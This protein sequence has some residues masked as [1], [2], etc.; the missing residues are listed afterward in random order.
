MTRNFSL[1]RGLAVA[2]A[3]VVLALPACSPVQRVG[4]WVGLGSRANLLTPDH[5]EFQRTAP[6][7]Y[8]VRFETSQGDFVVQVVRDWAPRGADRFYNLV[9][10]G[11]YDDVRFFRVLDGFMAQFGMSGDPAVT[12]A[13]QDARIPDDPVTRANTRGL[14]SFATAGPNTRTTQLFINFGDNSRLDGLGFAP[15]GHVIEGM[16]AVDR[17]YSGYGE[18]APAGRGPDQ[19][20]IRAEGNVYLEREFP[21][22]DR[23]VRARIVR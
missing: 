19:D 16:E 23:V 4:S 1:P 15:F 21:R 6:P 3:T 10:F 5:T 17:L 13:W 12:A 20:R 8:N 9:R 22:L 14:I 7:T 18:G 11:F 2:L